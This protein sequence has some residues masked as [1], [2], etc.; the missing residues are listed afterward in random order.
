MSGPGGIGYHPYFQLTD[1]P[2]DDWKVH[3]AA[4]DN[5][6]LSNLLIEAVVLRDQLAEFL[7]A[8]EQHSADGVI[9]RKLSV[10]HALPPLMSAR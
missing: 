6:E 1:S 9:E 4:R 3:L 7:M 8:L 10:C 2:R 5:V